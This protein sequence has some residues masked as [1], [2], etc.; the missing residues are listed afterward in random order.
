MLMKGG[1]MIFSLSRLK[2]L[3]AFRSGESRGFIRLR[4]LDEGMARGRESLPKE[5][6]QKCLSEFLDEAGNLIVDG[7]C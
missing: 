3:I 2:N 7:W 1:G 6:C 5:K 4:D